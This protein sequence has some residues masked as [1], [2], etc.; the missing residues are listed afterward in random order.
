MKKPKPGRPRKSAADK[1]RTPLR[2]FRCP[3]DLW[4]AIAEAASA[5]G[6]TASEWIREVLETR[7][8]RQRK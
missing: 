6:L 8:K 5:N 7:V 4:Q 2:S 3:D 1:F